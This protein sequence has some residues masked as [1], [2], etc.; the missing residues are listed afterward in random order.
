MARA[1][2]INAWKTQGNRGLRREHGNGRYVGRWRGT[3]V[4]KFDLGTTY[5]VATSRGT[6]V[7]YLDPTTGILI[8]SD[9][10]DVNKELLALIDRMR[11]E[12]I[13]GQTSAAS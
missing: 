1:I 2:K 4:E 3:D 6:H 9:V 13:A 12:R 8:P 7:Y 10:E 11:A 5:T